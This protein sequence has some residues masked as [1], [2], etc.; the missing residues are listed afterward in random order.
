M[1]RRCSS[2]VFFLP[3][4]ETSMTTKH[5]IQAK[6]AAET[7]CPNGCGRLYPLSAEGLHILRCLTCA[8]IYVTPKMLKE[9]E[10]LSKSAIAE[11]EHLVQPSRPEVARAARLSEDPRPCP[12]CH[13]LML[14]FTVECKETVIL[15]R[16][17]VCDGVW[18]DDHELAAAAVPIKDDFRVHYDRR[19]S[20]VIRDE[21]TAAIH[22]VDEDNYNRNRPVDLIAQVFPTFAS[23]ARAAEVAKATA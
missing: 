11:I 1:L 14:P 15:D 23:W 20:A 8:G 2:Y 13:T 6:T 22:E 10:H 19:L 18:A 7:R 3:P 12:R 21:V 9:L 4:E 5:P 17:G 16:C